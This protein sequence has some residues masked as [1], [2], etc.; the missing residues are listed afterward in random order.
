MK[1][2][3]NAV[4]DFGRLYQNGS[5]MYFLKVIFENMVINNGCVN[6]WVGIMVNVLV[7]GND[8]IFEVMKL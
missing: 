8:G 7:R 2:Q 4:Y 1:V 5:I 6:V 3:V